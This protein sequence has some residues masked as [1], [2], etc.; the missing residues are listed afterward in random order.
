MALILSLSSRADLPMRTNPQTGEVIKTTFTAAKLAHVVEYSVLALLLLRALTGPSGGSRLSL[1]I[2]T[3]VTVLVA[4]LFGG[5]D[6]IRQSFVPTR[7]P[8][9]TDVAL[10]TAS[11]LAACLAVVGWRRMRSPHGVSTCPRTELQA[12]A[13]PH[14]G[15]GSVGTSAQVLSDVVPQ[16]DRRAPQEPA[17]RRM[18][19]P[20][21]G[22]GPHRRPAGR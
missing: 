7:E 8:R 21:S 16:N 15:E 2:A 4:A 12:P 14:A 10:D 1:P 22:Q 18:F 9:L 13:L 3:G 11:A 19:S 6:E 17:S 5:I 20:R